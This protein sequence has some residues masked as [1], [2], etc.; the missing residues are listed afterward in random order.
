MDELVREGTREKLS[1]FSF[2]LSPVPG[3]STVERLPFPENAYLSTSKDKR[4][5]YYGG[6]GGFPSA[7]KSRSKTGR[8]GIRHPGLFTFVI[9]D[10]HEEEC[11]NC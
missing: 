2:D 4:T 1:S 10:A 6:G 11:K 8:R 3:R 9:R 5:E 7:N